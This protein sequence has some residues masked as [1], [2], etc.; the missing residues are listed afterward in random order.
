MEF[1]TDDTREIE[2][3]IEVVRRKAPQF[4]NLINSARRKW[5]IENLEDCVFGMMFGE[6]ISNATE[7]GKNKMI[8]EAQTTNVENISEFMNKIFEILN[9]HIPELKQAIADAEH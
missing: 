7:Y 8:D 5:E 3:I 9:E 2:Q 4:V 1:T 6:I